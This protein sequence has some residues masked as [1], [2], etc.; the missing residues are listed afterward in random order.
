MRHKR[1]PHVLF[2]L[3]RT[4]DRRFKQLELVV[5]RWMARGRR[6]GLE[7][8]ERRA[9]PAGHLGEPAPARRS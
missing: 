5:E 7:I 8:I 2:I 9:N 1:G 6:Y 4:P 3:V